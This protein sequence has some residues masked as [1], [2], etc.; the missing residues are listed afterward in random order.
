MF[1]Q[2]GGV[3]EGLAFAV[4]DGGIG[5]DSDDCGGTRVER[6]DESGGVEGAVDSWGYR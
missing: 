1:E 2:Y 5:A 3:I 6:R 4:D